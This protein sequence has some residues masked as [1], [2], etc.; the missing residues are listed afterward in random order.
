MSESKTPIL[1]I[2]DGAKKPKSTKEAPATQ[3]QSRFMDYGTL[4]V[5]FISSSGLRMV[6]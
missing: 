5:P 2:V 3:D 6:R 4:Q 1:K